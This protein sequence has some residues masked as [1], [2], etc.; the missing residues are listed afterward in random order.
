MSNPRLGC[1]SGG[2]QG[3][4]GASGRELGSSPTSDAKPI[5]FMVD[6]DVSVRKSPE[7]LISWKRREP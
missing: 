6:D 4:W 5:V 3:F 7:L 2:I 1:A